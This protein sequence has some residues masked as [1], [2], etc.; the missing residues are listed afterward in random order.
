MRPLPDSISPSPSCSISGA[1]RTLLS[2]AAVLPLLF[3]A[4][5][6]STGNEPQP[7]DAILVEDVP[8]DPTVVLPDAP[9]ATTGRF[10]LYSLR[11]NRIVL[12]SSEADPVIRARDSISTAWD[13]GFRG[14]SIIVNGGVSGP[15]VGAAQVLAEAFDQVTKAPA[16][17][18]AA[19][20][21]NECPGVETPAGTFPGAPLAI[22]NGSGNGWYVYTP[23][24]NLVTP[25]AGR[26]LVVR[27]AEDGSY[28]KVRI[29]SYYKGRPEDPDPFEDTS[30]Y[31]SFDYVYRPG[32]SDDLSTN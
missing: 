24:T 31:Y 3:S 15:G 8:A 1:R 14:T 32:G 11:E 5:G 10:T 18:Y 26:T 19:D 25:I 16:D 28:A 27:T 22:C 2:L 23:Q 29:L 7:L 4:C 21:E 12:P 17:G 30:R 20:G 13:L 9:P 6:N